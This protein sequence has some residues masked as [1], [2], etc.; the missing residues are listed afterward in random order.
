[1]SPR[2][3]FALGLGAAAGLAAGCQTYDFQPVEPVAIAQTTQ[4][5][6][7]VSR[8]LKP[9]LMLLVDRSGSMNQAAN[10][11]LCADPLCGSD[12]GHLKCDCPT[13]MSE[14]RLAMSDFLTKHGTVARMGLVPFATDR[15]TA[16]KYVC[17][18]PDLSDVEKL[19]V[20]LSQS[21]D[22]NAELQATADSIQARIQSLIPKGGTPTGASLRMLSNYEPLGRED[23]QDF[24]LLLTDGLPNCNAGNTC[25]CKSGTCH[26]DCDDASNTVKAVQELAA[27]SIRT[28]VVGFGAETGSALGA[29]P[30]NAMAEAGGFA[31]ACPDG[32][33]ATCGANNFCTPAKVCSKQFYQA[34]NGAELAAVLADIARDVGPTT[35][36]EYTLSAT[37]SDPRFL[38]VLMGPSESELKP[39]PPDQWTLQG[40]KLSFHTEG[41]ACRRLLA[42][43]PTHPLQLEFRILEGL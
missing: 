16:N 41:D 21:E 13:R 37:P 19:G 34:A 22:V 26:E 2:I 17:V 12:N 14:L 20:P 39:V 8:Q 15:L 31:R 38:S 42:A 1:M 33:S 43:S 6:R 40:P 25:A 32:D 9:N 4:T 5:T 24:V 7:V 23:R 28:I 10:P 30:L 36:C 29:G 27:K 3:L 18:A 35:A 11:S